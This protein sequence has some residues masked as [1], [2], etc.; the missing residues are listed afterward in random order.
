MLFRSSGDVGEFVPMVAFECR[1][2]DNRKVTSLKNEKKIHFGI[3][4][5]LKKVLFEHLSRV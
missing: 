1:G 4:K 5:N 3:K 2:L